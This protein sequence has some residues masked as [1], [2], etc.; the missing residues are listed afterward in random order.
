MH[1]AFRDYLREHSRVAAKYVRL[2]RK[3]A[4]K[5]D[6]TNHASRERYSLSKSDFINS[7]LKHAFAEG[8]PSPKPNR[9]NQ[10]TDPTLASVTP[11]A[12]QL[13]RHP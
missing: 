4:A 2:K 10:S 8:Y 9:P 12:V 11:A 6:D 3:L 5:H 7:V 1:L 13:A